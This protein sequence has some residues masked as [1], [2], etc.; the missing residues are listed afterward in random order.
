MSASP[1]KTVAF[2]LVALAFAKMGLLAP[3]VKL[4]RTPVPA[5]SVKMAGIAS[6][7]AVPAS[8]VSVAF[9]VKFLQT[10]V[11]ASSAKMA[12]FALAEAVPASTASRAFNAKMRRLTPAE[13]S[14]VSMAA[15]VGMD[16]AFVPGE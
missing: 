2:V 1:A 3:T 7:E 11:L 9:A 12:G 10:P 13:M 8:T 14:F 4:L 5:S 16:S 15:F 6:A